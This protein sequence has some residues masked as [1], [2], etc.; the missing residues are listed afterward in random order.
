M[1]SFSFSLT[2]KVAN[3]WITDDVISPGDQ[4]HNGP[5]PFSIAGITY[6]DKPLSGLYD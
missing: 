6:A 1:A 3:R 5:E 2:P 4:C